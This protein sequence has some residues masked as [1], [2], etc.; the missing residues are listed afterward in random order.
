LTDPVTPLGYWS[1]LENRIIYFIKQL[2]FRLEII[3]WKIF[4]QLADK[5]EKKFLKFMKNSSRKF[6]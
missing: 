1:F 6:V 3:A 2:A 5:Y 4:N